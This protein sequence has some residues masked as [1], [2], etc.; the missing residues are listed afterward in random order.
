[1]KIANF[2]GRQLS[3]LRVGQIYYSIIMSTISTLGIVNLAFPE[4][5]MTILIILFPCVFLVTFIAGYLIDIFNVGTMDTLK[6]VE[7]AHR[8]LNTVDFKTNEFHIMTM[9]TM[10]EWFKSLQENK[11]IDLDVLKKKYNEF[12]KKWSPPKRK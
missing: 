7:I 2:I 9:E 5:R 6:T 10:F 11:P 3:R 4:I 12:L 1:M 8:Y